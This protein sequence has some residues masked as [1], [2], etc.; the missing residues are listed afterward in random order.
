MGA[1][2]GIGYIASNAYA[3]TAGPNSKEG[4]QRGNEGDFLDEA[5]YSPI[6]GDV[7]GYSRVGVA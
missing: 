7:Y 6:D 4:R 5:H 2:M 3:S 1:A